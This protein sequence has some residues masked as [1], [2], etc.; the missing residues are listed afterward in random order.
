MAKANA[1]DHLFACI[2]SG[3]KKLNLLYMT[4]N[5]TIAVFED[6]KLEHIRKKY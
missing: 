5:E 1:P 6:D 3:R 2:F 4:E